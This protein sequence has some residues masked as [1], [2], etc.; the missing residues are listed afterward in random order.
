MP[1]REQAILIGTW[2]AALLV[3]GWLVFAGR[4]TA[5]R[6]G[7]GV[8]A[9]AVAVQPMN[10]E[11][12]AGWQRTATV[13][14]VT[15]FG[16]TCVL[17]WLL[18]RMQREEAR[19]AYARR[20]AQQRERLEAIGQLAGGITHDFANFLNI[21]GTNLALL[22]LQ[23]D[24][25]P[26]MRGILDSMDRAVHG[27]TAVTE[28]LLDVARRR[29]LK[30]APLHLDKWQTDALPLLTH[31]A[32]PDVKL[33]VDTKGSMQPVLCDA[34]QLDIAVVNLIANA[35]DAMGG[36][37]EISLEVFACDDSASDAPKFVT[38]SSPFVCLTVR[39]NGPGMSEEV[40]RHAV[41]PFFS[42]KGEN[43]TGL[44]LAQV[45]GFM[46]Q[47]GGYVTLETAPGR[48]TAVHLYFPVAP[49]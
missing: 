48:G 46:R 11:R 2:I 39:D 22:H 24:R 21:M 10:D 4:E 33:V 35:R 42:T 19:R 49:G 38:G 18:I 5:L 44:G 29:T 6:R 34:V 47:L 26:R 23:L 37:G 41:E 7:Q 25:Q 1:Y 43:G 20:R 3:V 17:A 8:N 45:Y 31:A 27:A 16:L 36:T 9:A 12:L 40:S 30:L 13:A 14:G 15:M 32:G 28:R